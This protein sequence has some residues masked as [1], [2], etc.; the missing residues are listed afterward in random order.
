MGRTT[1]AW[2]ADNTLPLI[3][4]DPTEATQLGA[5][6]SLHCSKSTLA[7]TPGQLKGLVDGVTTPDSL[8]S[9]VD[10][11]SDCASG[12]I[13]T[14]WSSATDVMAAVMAKQVARRFPVVTLRGRLVNL[15]I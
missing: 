3:R 5:S 15:A 8:E 12:A 9:P 14:M 4:E 13:V 1:P 7:E 6:W 10:E 2:R 11:S